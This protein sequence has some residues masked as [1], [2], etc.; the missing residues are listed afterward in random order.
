MLEA[1]LLIQHV[2]V[3]YLN[4]ET[5]ISCRHFDYLFDKFLRMLSLLDQFSDD[6]HA[7]SKPVWLSSNV[8]HRIDSYTEE[9]NIP[10]LL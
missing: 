10:S 4:K 7:I 6:C 3:V 5:H 2:S 1:L 9:D 8:N